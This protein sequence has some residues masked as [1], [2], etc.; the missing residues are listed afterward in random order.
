M[1]DRRARLMLAALG[2]NGTAR[3]IGL[4]VSPWSAATR[5]V[6][7]LRRRQRGRAGGSEPDEAGGGELEAGAFVRALGVDA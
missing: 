3:G 1:T 7:G 4:H 2:F 5:Q 6:G